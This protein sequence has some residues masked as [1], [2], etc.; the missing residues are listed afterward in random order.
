MYGCIV[1]IRIYASQDLCRGNSA[2][3]CELLS[4]RSGVNI[5]I[6]G[7]LRYCDAHA[8]WSVQYM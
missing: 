7:D 3:T 1:M 2:V 5:R 8:T 6:A 4:H